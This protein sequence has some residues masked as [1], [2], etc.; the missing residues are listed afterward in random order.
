MKTLFS[1]LI[2]LIFTI[3]CWSQPPLVINY[4]NRQTVVSANGTPLL[5]KWYNKVR[6]VQED[7]ILL[8]SDAGKGVFDNGKLIIPCEY[9]KIELNWFDGLVRGYAVCKNNRWAYFD[10]NGVRQTEFLYSGIK[11]FYLDPSTVNK[12]ISDLIQFEKDGKWYLYRHASNGKFIPFSIVG[13]KYWSDM[14]GLFI[15]ETNDL[16]TLYALD[17]SKTKLKQV[18]KPAAGLYEFRK[19]HYYFIDMKDQMKIFTYAHKLVGTG[20]VNWNK[21]YA[22]DPINDEYDIAQEIAADD[23]WEGKVNHEWLYTEGLI[24]FVT[25]TESKLA[26]TMN[27][28][29][30]L[31]PHELP[32]TFKVE[33][34]QKGKKFFAQRVNTNEEPVQLKFKKAWVLADGYPY[35]GVFNGKKYGIVTPDGESIFEPIYDEVQCELVFPGYPIVTVTRKERD[36]KGYFTPGKREAELIEIGAWDASSELLTESNMCLLKH[37]D[38]I[39]RKLVQPIWPITKWYDCSFSWKSGTACDSIQA[40]SLIPGVWITYLSGMQGVEIP[41]LNFTLPPVSNKVSSGLKFEM[42]HCSKEPLSHN[43]GI[44]VCAVTDNGIR[45]DSYDPSK[46]QWKI[47][48]INTPGYKS[49]YWLETGTILVATQEDGWSDLYDREGRLL[50]TQVK[51]LDGNQNMLSITDQGNFL[52]VEL[53]NGQWQAVDICKGITYSLPKWNEQ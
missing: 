3:F 15:A 30:A 2:F 31:V 41:Y 37:M 25:G 10:R 8:E 34:I 21:I 4:K 11:N 7:V 40:D 36:V 9:T 33:V 18:Q 39:G 46:E 49:A 44:N 14:N 35:I 23:F 19:A 22:D 45:A 42:H 13:A 24:S 27:C 51:V 17:P 48:T 20:P 43:I 32:K 5:S 50:S 53:R 26:Q 52:F 16:K 47:T 29:N 28:L 38:T 12:G 6:V 1:S